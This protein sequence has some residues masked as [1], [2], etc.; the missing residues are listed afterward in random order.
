MGAATIY[1]TAG[2]PS[3]TYRFHVE[4]KP[5]LGGLFDVIATTSIDLTF[6]GTSSDQTPPLLRTPVDLVVEAASAAGAIVSYSA[7]A[8]D[9][10]DGGVPV[11]CAPES[12]TTFP[13][14]TT[15]VQCIATD[16]AGNVASADFDV[17]VVD[18]TAPELTLPT[19][20]VLGATSPDGAPPA[21]MHLIAA[22]DEVDPEPV[23]SC[24]PTQGTVFP[25]GDTTVVCTATDV[26]GNSSQGSFP[27]HVKGAVEQLS[28]LVVL[29]DGYQLEKLGTSL[30]DKLAAA[31]LLL[32]DG[33][34]REAEEALAAFIA[35]VK[36]QAGKNLTQFQATTLVEA[37]VRIIAVIDA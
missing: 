18:T 24:M 29:I 28:D 19:G 11:T 32:D 26:A 14:G 5:V 27:V 23:V 36:A 9:D 34:L 6:I 4:Y 2:F 10:V 8:V 33:K 20:V 25:I 35:Q 13:L 15:N 1:S 16:G 12:G 30:Y 17:R 37:G 31:Q 7:S 22:T 21:Y 3:G